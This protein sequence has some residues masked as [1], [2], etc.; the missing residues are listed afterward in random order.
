[1][2][3]VDLSKG[4]EAVIKVRA[5]TRLEVDVCEGFLVVELSAGCLMVDFL[6]KG[7]EGCN[8]GV[9][10][11]VHRCA[12]ALHHQPSAPLHA[13]AVTFACVTC[14]SM[15]TGHTS[16]WMPFSSTPSVPPP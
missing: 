13:H 16:L 2:I 5:R 9:Y 15:R 12:P 3:K 14:K 1:V 11:G 6:S 4:L 7:L 8:Q 10:A